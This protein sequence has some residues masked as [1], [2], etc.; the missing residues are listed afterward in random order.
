MPRYRYCFIGEDGKVI[1]VEIFNAIDDGGA[2]AGA[3]QMVARVDCPAVDVWDHTAMIYRAERPLEHRS[4]THP[5]QPVK[6]R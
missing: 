3:E 5:K 2:G 4:T 6:P 1:G